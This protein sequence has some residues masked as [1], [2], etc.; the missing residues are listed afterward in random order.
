MAALEQIGD[1][2]I[3]PESVEAI[4]RAFKDGGLQ[5][6]TRVHLRNGSCVWFH[7][8]PSV[9]AHQIADALEHQRRPR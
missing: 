4:D 6:A 1:Y 3:D 2:W 7:D 5:I 9:I 8:P